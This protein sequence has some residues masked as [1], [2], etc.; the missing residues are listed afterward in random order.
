[1]LLFVSSSTATTQF[2]LLLAVLTGVAESVVYICLLVENDR[3][4]SFS[5]FFLFLLYDP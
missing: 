5:V 1:M 3:G 4:S 2:Q